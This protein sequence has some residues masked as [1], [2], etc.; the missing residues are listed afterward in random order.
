MTQSVNTGSATPEGN[1]PPAG[2]DQQMAQKFDQQQQQAQPPQQPTPGNDRPAWLPE[3]F[4]SGEDLA[5][6]YNEL[7]K[8]LGGGQQQQQQPPAQ[9]QQQSQDAARQTVEAAGLDFDALSQEFSKSGK[10]SP[11][12]YANL[13]QRGIPQKTVDEYIAGQQALADN[14]RTDVLS[15]IGGEEKFAEI[16]SWAGANMDPAELA[17]Y[18]E[19]IQNGSEGQIKLAIEA[20]NARY[21]AA[22]GQTPNLISGNSGQQQNAGD[23]F[24]SVPELT[25][26]MADPRYATDPAY[27]NDVVQK[28]ARSK[29]M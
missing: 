11:E 19:T 5:K 21:V 28:L 17:A 16:A 12:T 10:L 6:A 24:R 13:A 1:Q 4:N 22:N 9:Q 8:K 2:H 20:L 25:K 27:R 26:A 29:I 18:N 7:Q 23:V 15:T 3:K 14:L